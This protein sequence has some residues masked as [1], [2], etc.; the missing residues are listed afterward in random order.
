MTLSRAPLVALPLA[1]LA[2][3]ACHSAAEQVP[4]DARDRQPWHEIAA[5]ETVRF[6][7]TEPFWGGRVSAAG[8]TYTTPDNEKGE[9]VPVSRFAG[10]GGVSFSGV[11]AAGAMT[12]AVTPG[13]CSDGMSDTRYPFI[14][15]L[16]VGSETRNGCGWTDR[17][18]RLKAP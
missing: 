1:L 2:V 7:G 6:L 18:P 17:K 3:A 14:V 9:S 13:A 11:L 15:T 16:Q 8:M 10:R 4:G 5:D 12:L